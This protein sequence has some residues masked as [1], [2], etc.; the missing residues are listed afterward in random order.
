MMLH[1]ANPKHPAIIKEMTEVVEFEVNEKAF[2]E[3]LWLFKKYKVPCRPTKKGL[4]IKHIK[5]KSKFIN[6]RNR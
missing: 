5:T 2:K 1:R 6:D 4:E 3:L